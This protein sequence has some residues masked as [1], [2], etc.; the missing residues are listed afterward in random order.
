M[1]RKLLRTIVTVLLLLVMV[2]PVSAAEYDAV[3]DEWS[4]E[5]YTDLDGNGAENWRYQAPQLDHVT[6]TMNLLTEEQWQRLEQKARE[7]EQ[8]YDFGVYIVTVDDYWNY[9]NGSVM[10]AAISIYQAYSLGIGDGKDGLML[11]LSMYDRDYSLITHGEFGNYAFNDAGRERLASFFLDD[12]GNDQWY[13]GFEDF[14][15]WS[16][17]YL[18]NAKNGNPY[19]SDHKAMSSADVFMGIVIRVL[20]ILIFPLIVAGIYIGVLN[21]KMKNVEEATRASAY[22]SGK[23][24]LTKKT[25][26]FRFVTQNRV[27]ISSSSS[28]GGGTR[29]GSSGGFSGTSGKF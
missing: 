24:N 29:S 11:L 3:Q 27:K 18:E 5:V 13:T 28:S 17:D 23:L 1:K 20:I 26:K 4:E 2:L 14:L 9:N 19:S 7:I 21:S 22:V 10:D 6:D 25:D 8:I 16:E 12:F 15:S